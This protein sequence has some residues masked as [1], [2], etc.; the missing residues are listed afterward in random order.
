M[1]MHQKFR[2]FPMMIASLALLVSPLGCHSDTPTTP[3]AEVPAQTPVVSDGPAPTVASEAPAEVNQAAKTLDQEVQR[4]ETVVKDEVDNLKSD[5]TRTADSFKELGGKARH[6]A[7][8][9]A[10]D[11]KNK[12]RNAR[13][14]VKKSVEGTK[15]EAERR[16]RAAEEEVKKSAENALESLLGNPK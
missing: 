3:V 2:R 1:D 10:K 13:S 8:Q 6:D 16:I 14:D 5:A 15:E 11:L 7:E 4:T 12:V 9:A